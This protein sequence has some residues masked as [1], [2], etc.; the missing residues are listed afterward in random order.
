[1]KA[2]LDRSQLLGAVGGVAVLLTAGGLAWLGLAGLGEKQAEAQALADRLANPALAAL[3]VDSQG[4]NRAGRDATE[5]QKLT[6]DLRDNDRMAAGWSEATRTLA[7]DEADWAKDPGKWKDRLIAI[8][9]QLQKQSQGQKVESRPDFYLG[10]EDFRQKSPTADEVPGLALHLSVAE[11]LVQLLMEARQVAEQYPTPC[12]LLSL[13]GPGSTLAKQGEELPPPVAAPTPQPKL[14]APMSQTE[15]KSFRVEIRSSPEVL[16]EYV[17]L[18]AGNP[19]LLIVTNLIVICEQQNFPLRSEIAKKFS[20]T[21]LPTVGD[22]TKKK[23]EGKKLLEILAGEESVQT[24]LE[25]DFVAWKPPG[26]PKAGG[27][28]DSGP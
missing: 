9:S 19:A 7:G 6:K 28:P 4:V 8:Q 24:V 12:R 14:G 27:S 17:R 2:A 3:L 11:R 23:K 13:S 10:L 20:E 25:V 16:Y 26:E 21:N 5:I 15:R 18:L 1:M 22:A